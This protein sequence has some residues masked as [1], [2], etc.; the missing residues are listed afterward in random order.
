MICC[1]ICLSPLLEEED[2]TRLRCAHGFHT[3]CILAWLRHRPSCPLCRRPVVARPG[4]AAPR[5][6]AVD[7]FVLMVLLIFFLNLYIFLLLYVGWLLEK[8]MVSV[9]YVIGEEHEWVFLG[10]IR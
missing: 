1:S 7:A 10:G 3:V 4:V 9:R 5:M 6:I 8:K 2:T